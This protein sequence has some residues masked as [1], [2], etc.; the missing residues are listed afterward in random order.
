DFPF[1]SSNRCTTTSGSYN[2]QPIQSTRSSLRQPSFHFARSARTVRI[3]CSNQLNRLGLVCSAFARHYLRNR[4]RF[5][6]LRLLRCFTSPGVAMSLLCI[7]R[8]SSRCYPTQV[9]PFGN[10]R[11]TACLPLSEAYRS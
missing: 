9:I 3:N 4:F 6:F 8:D 5:L 10:P 2:P 1:A 7:H 11:V